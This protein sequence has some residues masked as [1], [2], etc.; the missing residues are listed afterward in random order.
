[1]ALE[2]SGFNELLMYTALG[3]AYLQ[4]S[5]IFGQARKL[6][7]LATKPCCKHQVWPNSN[8]CRGRHTSGCHDSRRMQ[9][10]Q[11]DSIRGKCLHV[12]ISAINCMM[13]HVYTSLAHSNKGSKRKLLALWVSC[14]CQR[15]LRASNIFVGSQV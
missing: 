11:A 3:W 8:V 5:N 14:T 7:E 10:Q 13:S 6:F 9:L 1:M 15:V 4:H 2:A 12:P